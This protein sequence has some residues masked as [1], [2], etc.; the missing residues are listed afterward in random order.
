MIMWLGDILSIIIVAKILTIAGH[1]LESL[2]RVCCAEQL[3]A[4][5]H[6]WSVY[7]LPCSLFIYFATCQCFDSRPVSAPVQ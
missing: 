6:L 4:R 7:G 2:P 5:V 1:Y 3:V